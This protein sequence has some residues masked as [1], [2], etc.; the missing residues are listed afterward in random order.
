MLGHASA[1]MTLDRFS[2]VFGDAL[3]GVADQLDKA[4]E[5]NVV[6]PSCPQDVVTPLLRDSARV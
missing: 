2:H 6:P 3:E 5:R 1:A 4:R